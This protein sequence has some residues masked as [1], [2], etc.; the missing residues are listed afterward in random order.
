MLQSTTLLAILV[1][2]ALTLSATGEPTQRDDDDERMTWWREAR[3]GLFIHWGLYAI[4]A[5]EWEGSTNHAEWILTTARIPVA[6]YEQFAAEFNPVKFDAEAWVL[7]AK[8][9]GMRYIVIT[10]K[11][12]DG[13]CLW[14]S[15][16]TDYDVMSTP[17]KRDILAELADACRRHGIKLCFYHSIMDWHHPEY[18]PRRDWEDRPVGD[19]NF[20]DYTTYLRRQCAEL[21]MNYGDVGVMWFDGEWEHTW[22]HRHGQPL[23]DL[24]RTLQ[25]NV[26]VNNR[27]DVGRAGMAGFTDDDRY[28]GDFGTPEQEIPATGLPGVDWE[29]CMTMNRHWG[30]NK[31]D[32]DWKTTTDLVQKLCDIASKGGN[33]LLNVGPKADGT[34]PDESI[35]RLREIGEWLDVNGEAIYATSAS[36]FEGLE[37]GRCT[38]KRDGDLTRFYFHVF[39]WQDALHVP[40]VGNMVHDSYVLATGERLMATRREGTVSIG[41][42]DQPPSPHASVIVLEVEG[43]PIVYRS[44]TINADGNIFVH[45]TTVTIDAGSD[46]LEVRY[47]TDGSDPAADSPVY[48]SPIR[49]AGTTTIKARSFHRG[50][51][52]T[53]IVERTIERVEPRRG[54]N[55][56]T[57][58]PGVRVAYYPGD[59]DELPGFDALE[60]ERTWTTDTIGLGDDLTEYYGLVVTGY[61]TVS[62][63]D[64][65]TF[66]LTSDDGSRLV[67]H[68]TVVVDN[69]GLHGPEA[70]IGQIALGD[71]FHPFR[72]E[73]FNKTGGAE[74]ELRWGR[75]GRNVEI[76]PAAALARDP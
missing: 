53:E 1:G 47:T 43:A 51:P 32:D 72:I 58:A 56:F 46:G 68:D 19:A 75:I 37:W 62:E 45:P 64:V 17:F 27:V 71:G 49:I 70:Q 13:F 26:I 61:I 40:N 21:L 18:L 74:L 16:H 28:A 35:E 29:T 23:Y 38:V 55:L 66:D 22:S 2:L 6:E 34:F 69:D 59:W 30:Y 54:L 48:E 11:H 42:P 20:D 67:I 8:G 41:L 57:S 60:P 25:P 10:S 4:P 12:H 76:V 3:F 63:P 73:Y 36:P 65:Y 5:G 9:A 14:D 52:V 50:R 7:A 33:F 24:C 31:H 44:P 39:D 15:E